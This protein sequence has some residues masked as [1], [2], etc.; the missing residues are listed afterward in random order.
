MKV[1]VRFQACYN[2]EFLSPSA[3]PQGGKLARREL[4]SPK[5]H[6]NA[7]KLDSTSVPEWL[8]LERVELESA[9]KEVSVASTSEEDKR[10]FRGEVSGAGKLI[11]GPL[12]SELVPASV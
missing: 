5:T 2:P 8:P 11:D 4:P 12:G 6:S 9:P 3:P 10:R 1:A 7:V